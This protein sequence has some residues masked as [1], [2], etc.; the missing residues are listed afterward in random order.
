MLKF[1]GSVGSVGSL[2]VRF[3]L[4][5][6]VLDSTEMRKKVTPPV[7]ACDVDTI[8]CETFDVELR[9]FL[10]FNPDTH[11]LVPEINPK[12]FKILPR[13]ISIRDVILPDY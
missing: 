13:R 6:K 11:L 5:T 4:S 12:R 2:V 7:E 1:I 10:A 3:L 8:E 9:S